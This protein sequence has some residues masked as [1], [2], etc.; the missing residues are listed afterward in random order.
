MNNKVIHSNGVYMLKEKE[1]E[2][3]VYIYIR[4]WNKNEI[5]FSVLEEDTDY[6][7][8]SNCGVFW[9]KH[10]DFN[11][12]FRKYRTMKTNNKTVGCYAKTSKN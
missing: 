6:P 11:R 12:M 1:D 7:D 2:I 5:G 9:V 10:K 4:G 3:D 8:F